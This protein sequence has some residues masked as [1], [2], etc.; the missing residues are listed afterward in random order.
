MKGLHVPRAKMVPIDNIY[1]E[2]VLFQYSISLFQ[3]PGELRGNDC[4]KLKIPLVYKFRG[5]SNIGQ[6]C[7][8]VSEIENKC[9]A[10]QIAILKCNYPYL[11]ISRIE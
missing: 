4:H 8:W 10:V 9:I 6:T 5:S 2:F 1:G 11:K 3:Y 7:L